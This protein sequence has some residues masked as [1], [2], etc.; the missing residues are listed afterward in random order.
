[1]PSRP[2]GSPCPASPNAASAY[3]IVEVKAAH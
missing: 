1:M 2:F 3:V